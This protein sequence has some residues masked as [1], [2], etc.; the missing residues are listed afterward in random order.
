MANRLTG[1][2]NS[3]ANTL[4]AFQNIYATDSA[5]R[6]NTLNTAASLA[7]QEMQDKINKYLADVGYDQPNINM[8]QRLAETDMSPGT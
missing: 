5:E 4:N 1:M 6:Q 7:Q 2:E 8:C 3:N